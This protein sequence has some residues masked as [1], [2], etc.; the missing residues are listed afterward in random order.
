MASRMMATLAR[1]TS[2]AITMLATP[3]TYFKQGTVGRPIKV[4]WKRVAPTD[5]EIINAYG[6]GALRVTIPAD[7]ISPDVP[8]QFDRLEL[9]GELYTIDYVGAN[10]SAEILVSYLCYTMGQKQ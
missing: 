8:A 9:L 3:A 5:T 1:E 6:L 7:A 4:G 2:R 10:Y